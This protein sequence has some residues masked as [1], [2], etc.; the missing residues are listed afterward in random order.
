MIQDIYPSRLDNSFYKCEP[1]A[2]DTVFVF[3]REGKVLA[4]MGDGNLRFTSASEA[5]EGTFVYLFSVDEKKYF[6]KTDDAD[7]DIPGYEL[8]SIRQLRDS[9]SGCE[10]FAAFTGYH[11]CLAP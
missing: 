9:S 3:D 11:L 2:G 10:L 4:D 7:I 1:E 5:G 6:L 8:Y